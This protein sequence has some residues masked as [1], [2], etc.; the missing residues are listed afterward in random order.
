MESFR[1]R[2]VVAPQVRNFFSHID[3]DVRSTTTKQGK[4]SSPLFCDFTLIVYHPPKVRM[5]SILL[6]KSLSSTLG[7]SSWC[8]AIIPSNDRKLPVQTNPR[9]EIPTRELDLSAQYTC[10][11]HA[12][13]LARSK[14]CVSIQQNSPYIIKRRH[15][16]VTRMCDSF[17]ESNDSAL[18]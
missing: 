2:G 7:K 13:I 6:A 11:L 1:A 17:E 10:T 9:V 16:F 5:Q 18:H 15:V 3:G 4:H 12:L 8:Y 14:R